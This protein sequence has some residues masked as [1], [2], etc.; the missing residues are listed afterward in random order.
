MLHGGAKKNQQNETKKDVERKR[1]IS[2]VH[3]K[4]SWHQRSISQFIN[5]FEAPF[6]NP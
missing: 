1:E 2:R 6:K 4:S 3:S 5:W